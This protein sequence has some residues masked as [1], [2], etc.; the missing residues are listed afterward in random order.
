MDV[1]GKVNG[2]SEIK[3]IPL[4]PEI[5]YQKPSWFNANSFKNPNTYLL[6][7]QLKDAHP[8]CIEKHLDLLRV[9]TENAQRHRYY[10]STYRYDILSFNPRALGILL[11]KVDYSIQ[12]N[13][14]LIEDLYRYSFIR[15]KPHTNT[16]ILSFYLNKT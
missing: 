4:M 10:S 1:K 13:R 12:K 3:K 8:D 7:L 6:E 2:N 14:T 9:T 5:M 16:N 15:G 11:S